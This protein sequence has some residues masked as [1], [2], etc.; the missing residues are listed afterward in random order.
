M[1]ISTLPIF[2]HRKR[3]RESDLSRSVRIQWQIANMNQRMIRSG[4][5]HL[6][7]R[8][9][10]NAGEQAYQVG[11]CT[12]GDSRFIL[13]GWGRCSPAQHTFTEPLCERL[14]IMNCRR[15][16]NKIKGL[17]HQWELCD[18]CGYRYHVGVQRS[19]DGD[20]QPSAIMPCPFH[21]DKDLPSCPLFL[22][23]CGNK[24]CTVVRAQHQ[25]RRTSGEMFSR[26]FIVGGA[27]ENV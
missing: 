27:Y 14:A 3:V 19:P 16:G 24:P 9:V 12:W 1:S 4:S 26:N 5:L 23:K 21:K 10:C 25:Q 2:R 18:K 15:C 6:P 22:E 7:T 20:C 17:W 11:G 8:K 13:R